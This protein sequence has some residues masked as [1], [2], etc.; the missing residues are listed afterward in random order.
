[1]P[2][3][4]TVP[5]RPVVKPGDMAYSPRTVEA[6]TG[7]RIRPMESRRDR[8]AFVKMPWG[9]YRGNE[10]WVPPMIFDQ[11]RFLD[12]RKGTFFGHGE[13]QL[14]LATLDGTPAGRI[15]AHLNTDPHIADGTGFFG[16]FECVDDQDVADA[17]FAAAEDYLHRRGRRRVEG[18]MSFGVYDEIGVLLD[19]YDEDPF[20]LTGYNPPYYPRLLE[21]AGYRKC[22]DWHAFRGIAGVTDRVTD[23]RFYAMRERT[24]KNADLQIRPMEVRKHLEREKGIIRRIFDEA[25]SR[26]WGHVP[27]TDEEFERLAGQLKGVVIPEL[28]LVAEHGGEPVGITLSTYDVNVAVKKTNGRLFPIGAIR[29][30]RNLKRTTRFRLILMGVLEEHRNIGVHVALIGTVIEN[31]L[32]LGFTEAEL[33]LVVETNEPMLS[34]FKTVRAERSKTYRIYTKELP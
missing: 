19:G 1:M 2:G 7:L 27:L 5:A 6:R 30:L 32:R 18:P 12:P 13:A 31:A 21:N 23:P 14:F 22:V 3:G 29:L 26:N 11:M 24:V 4:Q 33:S 34:V 28:S 15:S 20:V 10:H 8:S 9:V 17:L 25:W 16:F